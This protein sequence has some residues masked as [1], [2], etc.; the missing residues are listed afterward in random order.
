M[1]LKFKSI[2]SG[3]SGNCL[4]LWTERTTVLIDCGIRSRSRCQSLIKEHIGG[5]NR[6]NAV[7]VSHLHHDHI[8]PPSLQVL[9]CA[10]VLIRCHEGSLKRLK[11][12]DLGRNSDRELR[13]RTFA[14]RPF[15]IREFLFQ[16]IPVP[17]SP[18]VS[19]F[20]FVIHC[21]TGRIRRKIVVMTDLCHW[22]GLLDH[23]VGADF[24]FVE[25]NHDPGLLRKNPNFNS[26]FHMKNE[27]TAWLIHHVRRQSPSAPKAIMLG[28]ISAKRNT[29]Q[30]IL[31]TFEA[32][33]RKNGTPRDFKLY[34]ADREEASPTIEI[35]D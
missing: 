5:P 8:C 21:R 19:N 16:P 4:M 1:S 29:K 18:E 27:K 13:I 35:S 2:R 28:H 33:F 10:G 26:R 15:R 22:Q 14:D 17:H 6:I 24:I 34:V 12:I 23:F 11:G 30:L 9:G 32:V 25:S 7:V 20:G 31:D 3:S